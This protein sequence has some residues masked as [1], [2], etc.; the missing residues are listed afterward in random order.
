M[1]SIIPIIIQLVSGAVGG[2][3]AGAIKS[4]SLG[5]TGN[6]IAGGLGGLLI[7]QGMNFLLSS[8]GQAM[9]TGVLGQVVGSG[10]AGILVTAIIGFIRNAMNKK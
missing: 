5:S 7:G 9:L 4:L 2:N 6:S 1:E 10:V 8:T 3:I